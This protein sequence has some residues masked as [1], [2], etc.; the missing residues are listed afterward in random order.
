MSGVHAAT[1][2]MYYTATWSGEGGGAHSEPEL[3]LAVRLEDMGWI[4]S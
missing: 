4:S 1:A 3:A 2:L